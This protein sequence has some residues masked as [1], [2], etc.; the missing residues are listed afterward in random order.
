MRNPLPYLDPGLHRRGDFTRDTLQ[1]GR[2]NAI[3]VRSFQRL[4]R[5]FQHNSLERVLRP[6]GST[7][8]RWLHSVTGTTDPVRLT[9]ALHLTQTRHASPSPSL[10]RAGSHPLALDA[11][12]KRR[13]NPHA[14]AVRMAQCMTRNSTTRSTHGSSRARPAVCP[15]TRRKTVGDRRC[16]ID[17]CSMAHRAVLE[18]C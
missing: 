3:I 10:T 16:A 6:T 4:P 14:A 12:S 17:V 13:S 1:H 8:S 15:D 9:L 11:S 2:I 7:L 18:H 5:D